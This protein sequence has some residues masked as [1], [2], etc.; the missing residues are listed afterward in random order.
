MFKWLFMIIP[1]YISYYTFSYANMIRKKEKNR[2]GFAGVSIISL[3]ILL[4]PI[5]LALR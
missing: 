2:L 4:F 5:W 1:I 3:I